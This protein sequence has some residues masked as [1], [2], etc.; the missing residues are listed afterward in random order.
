MPRV[1][2]GQCWPGS[3]DWRA[4]SHTYQPFP[5]LLA[6]P[7]GKASPKRG[8]ALRGLWR[9]WDIVSVCKPYLKAKVVMA[10][11]R[12]SP[13]AGSGQ[14]PG[15]QCLQPPGKVSVCSPLQ[16]TFEWLLQSQE[17]SDAGA[18]RAVL[19]PCSLLLPTHKIEQK[20]VAGRLCLLL[21]QPLAGGKGQALE[22][23]CAQAGA[24]TVRDKPPS[25]VGAPGTRQ[26]CPLL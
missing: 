12:S 25:P 6:L 13:A 2:G 20:C 9:V 4:C 1:G 18:A 24:A 10:A 8:P 17:G 15:E 7:P 19:F 23:G 3:G 14:V 22:P 26:S 11:S 21:L 5:D 16:L